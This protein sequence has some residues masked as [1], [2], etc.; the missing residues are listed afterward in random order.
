MDPLSAFH[1]R[2]SF[3]FSGSSSH[4]TSPRWRRRDSS[5]AWETKLDF[6]HHTLL[7]RKK[8]SLQSCSGLG[9]IVI[10]I[11]LYFTLLFIYIPSF[12]PLY[13]V[14][15]LKRNVNHVLL[16]AYLQSIWLVLQLKLLLR[17]NMVTCGWPPFLCSKSNCFLLDYKTS[18]KGLNSSSFSKFAVEQFA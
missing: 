2:I 7:R 9:C 11:N 5:L 1:S 18:W 4:E 14:A 8:I 10:F 13:I 6:Y 15:F 16:V 12:L 3:P 17:L